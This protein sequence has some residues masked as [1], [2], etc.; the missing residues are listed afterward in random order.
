MNG[1]LMAAKLAIPLCLISAAAASGAVLASPPSAQQNNSK[2]AAQIVAAAKGWRRSHP[3]RHTTGQTARDARSSAQL[4]QTVRSRLRGSRRGAVSVGPIMST[5]TQA[6]L[7][8]GGIDL[9]APDT[10][11]PPVSAGQANSAAQAFM[12]PS[13]QW[14]VRESVLAD[15]TGGDPPG[16]VNRPWPWRGRA[17][18]QT[19]ALA[20]RGALAR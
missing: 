10:Q 1:R 17:A 4:R 3:V 16:T 13:Q 14:T 20:I 2:A 15:Y 19:P 7:V 18:S 12:D 5:V 9:T 6:Q 11:T 8:S